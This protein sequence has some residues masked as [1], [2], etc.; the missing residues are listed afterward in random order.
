MSSRCRAASSNISTPR[1][2]PRL[3]WC[4]MFTTA[5]ALRGRISSR[6]TMPRGV[7]C[8]IPR[9]CEPKM[10][11]AGCRRADGLSSPHPISDAGMGRWR[12]DTAARRSSVSVSTVSAVDGPAV[13]GQAGATAR[14]GARCGDSAPSAA[15]G[16][17]TTGV[18]M[19][20]AAAVPI[21]R[22]ASTAGDAVDGAARRRRWRFPLRPNLLRHS[23]RPL[24]RRKLRRPPAQ[25]RRV[26]RVPGR[27]QGRGHS[28]R[29]R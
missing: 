7:C 16:A 21:R 29:L 23:P 3:I 25:G 10:R 14:S 12:A 1:A 15:D 19:T 28:R 13:G 27:E 24:R 26:A 18:S 4:A 2:L 8:A 6:F 17:T 5:M 20:N 9:R 22:S 11:Q